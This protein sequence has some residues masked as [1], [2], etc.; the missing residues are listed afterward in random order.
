MTETLKLLHFIIFIMTNIHNNCAL[1][2]VAEIRYYE[3]YTFQT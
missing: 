2:K 1:F 3:K